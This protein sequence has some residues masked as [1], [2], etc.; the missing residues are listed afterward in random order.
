M[1]RSAPEPALRFILFLLFMAAGSAIVGPSADAQERPVLAGVTL[2]AQIWHDNINE[3]HLWRFKADGTIESDYWLVE[4]GTQASDGF[5]E[6]SDTG[7]WKVESGRLCIRWKLMFE[8]E[9][10][11]YRLTPVRPRWVRFSNVSGG[12][13][14]FDAQISR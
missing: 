14:S 4:N 8:A 12:A 3:Q 5:N 2:R 9:R 7:R 6:E 10:Q 1:F 13:P 11:C